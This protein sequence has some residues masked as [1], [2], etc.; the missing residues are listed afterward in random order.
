MVPNMPNMPRTCARGCTHA[1]LSRVVARAEGSA[2]SA[3]TP[4]SGVPTG[5]LGG[6]TEAPWLETAWGVL[7]DAARRGPL[8]D[9]DPW[10][11]GLDQLTA[12]YSA[13]TRSLDATVAARAR[14]RLETLGA[15]APAIAGTA[16]RSGRVPYE[17]R[18]T[19]WSGRLLIH[20]P[21]WQF[22]TKD[23]DNVLRRAVVAPKGSRILRADW[24]ASHLYLLAGLSG[25]PTLR[26]DLCAG[27]I[28]HQL[29]DN[30]APSHPRARD[31]GKL[32][33]LAITYRAGAQTLCAKA[34]EMGI[35]LTEQQVRDHIDQ[36]R[37]RYKVL[38]QWGHEIDP[39]GRHLLWVPSGRRI[40]LRP[41][42]DQWPPVPGVPVPPG[43]PT[44]LSGI[45]QAWEA[46]ALLRALA[47]LAPHMRN[48][49]LRLVLHLHD[50]TVWE[51]P[52]GGLYRGMRLVQAAMQQAHAW[53]Q[54]FSP[55]PGAPPVERER[56]ETWGAPVVAELG[57]SWGGRARENS[58][59]APPAAKHTPNFSINR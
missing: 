2:C 31:L 51:V 21:L 57:G 46:D 40:Q 7:E 47:D 11:A 6:T 43:L 1:P 14:D 15:Y 18:E 49:G 37:A 5:D 50:C 39:V 16:R 58:A 28:Y 8:V 9:A 29:G 12:T 42:L 10:Q 23:G 52:L 44:L 26:A 30:L 34:R 27:D 36:I 3:A 20:G 48:H 13:A 45:A 53:V 4:R 59:R 33:V 41:N 17:V 38:W 24:R 22:V 56:S 55:R 35:Q 25:D 19:D 54:R 32:M